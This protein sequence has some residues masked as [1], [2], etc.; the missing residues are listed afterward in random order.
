MPELDWSAFGPLHPVTRLRRLQQQ[1]RSFAGLHAAEL[2]ALAHELRE[3][4]HE[5]HAARLTAFQVL[6][7]QEAALVL[8]ELTDLASDLA[9]GAGPSSPESAPRARNRPLEPG[10]GPS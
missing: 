1:V 10:I 9:A 2:S 4:G 8:E 3:D 6:H 7:D 5:G